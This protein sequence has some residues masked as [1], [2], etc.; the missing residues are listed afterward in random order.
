MIGNMISYALERRK[1]IRQARMSRVL[2]NNS[3]Q[4][5]AREISAE[6]KNISRSNAYQTLR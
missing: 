4:L 1:V 6:P 5:R 2:Q 3:P